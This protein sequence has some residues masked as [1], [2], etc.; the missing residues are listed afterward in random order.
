MAGSSS[1]AL[2]GR[3][4]LRFSALSCIVLVL[5]PILT[6]LFCIGIGRY[7]L[8]ISESFQVLMRGFM[9]GKDAVEPQAYSVIF[10]IRLPRILLAILCGSGMA[11]SGAAYQAIFT[12]PLASPDTLGVTYGASFGAAVALLSRC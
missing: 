7:S 4:H 11:V 2:A 9:Y 3:S 10:N 1:Q 5:L 6:G 12:I 8:T